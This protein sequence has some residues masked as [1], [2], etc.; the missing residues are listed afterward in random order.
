[1]ILYST[2]ASGFLEIVLYESGAKINV[3]DED[4]DTPMHD[5][6]FNGHFLVVNYLVWK[7]A[8]INHK[9]KNGK[10]PLDLAVD[11]G[12]EEIAEFLRTKV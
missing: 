11:E 1:L 4:G 8:E 7:N 6:A 10:T 9:N 3:V 12:N 5:A 2:A